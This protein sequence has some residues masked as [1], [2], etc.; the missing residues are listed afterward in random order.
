MLADVE[1][2]YS[3]R[4]NNCSSYVSLPDATYSSAVFSDNPLCGCT[5]SNFVD[6][7]GNVDSDT[8]YDN[9]NVYAIFNSNA[10]Y[11][12]YRFSLN[13]ISIPPISET[14]K[15]LVYSVNSSNSSTDNR[16]INAISQTIQNNFQYGSTYPDPI[17]IDIYLQANGNNL[18]VFIY[19]SDE[20][21]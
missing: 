8:I 2:V 11:Q 14:S 6:C 12:Y 18:D 7:N 16:V 13:R 15:V 10:G 3:C 19:P 4:P 20:D 17:N 21:Q 5:I 9:I 1:F